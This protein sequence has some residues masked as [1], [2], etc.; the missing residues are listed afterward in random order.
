MIWIVGFIIG[1]CL[2]SFTKVIADRSL[3]NKS[4]WGRSY[5]VSCK[6]NLAWYDLFPI[7]SYL[8]FRGKCSHCHKKFSSEYLLVEVL[9]GLLVAGIFHKIIPPQF[10]EINLVSWGVVAL[11]LIMYLVITIILVAVFMTDFKTGYIPDRITHPGI[12]I[13]FIL[14]IISA[15]YNITLFY[16]SLKFSDLGKYL[17]PGYSNYFYVN[18]LEIASP[19]IYGSLMALVLGLFFYL[20]I[21]LTKGKGMG[22]GDLKLGVFLGLAF[23]F[24]YSLVVLMLSFLLGSLF[25]IGLILIGKKKFGQTLPFGPF[26]SLAGL[27]VIF[28]G[29]EILNWYLNLS[30]QY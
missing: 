27:I 5:C 22:G 25:G 29:S 8:I 16:L 9:M 17:L 11:S 12:W 13:L 24:P 6:R 1:I 28:W 7:F 3:T 14:Q 10:L 23:G 15:I 19:L 2:G 4:F 21:V 18:A 26:M 30:L 20:L